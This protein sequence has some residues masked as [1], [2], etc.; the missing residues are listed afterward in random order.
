[1][2]K[3]ILDNVNSEIDFYII[4]DNKGNT[5]EYH[6]DTKDVFVINRYEG[7]EGEIAKDNIS[8]EIRNF[9]NAL[10]RW[11]TWFRKW[12]KTIWVQEDM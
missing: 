6:L 7:D 8:K 2:K 12:G 5:Y 3:Y 9:C 4:H 11:F 1:M 10:K